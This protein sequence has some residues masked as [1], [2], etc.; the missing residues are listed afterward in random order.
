MMERPDCGRMTGS[1]S[2][3][4]PRM[5]AT[6]MQHWP[7]R[8]RNCRGR[9]KMIPPRNRCPAGDR[10]IT[11]RGREDNRMLSTEGRIEPAPRFAIV[12]YA[13]RFPG[14]QDA[15]E[16]WDVL[17]EGRDAISEVPKDRW[18]V[19]EFFDPEPGV[20]GKVVTRRAGFVDDVTGFDAP[21]FGMST[22][23]VMLM[24]PQ[25]LLLLKKA[26]L[27]ER[28]QATAPTHMVNTNT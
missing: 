5:S 6:H 21:F 1:R 2:S 10:I 12:G 8:G 19:D 4:N 16:F 11:G 24:D 18:D 25:H 14:A 27:R 3:R 15:D 9:R 13:A 22:R 17:R 20:P 28:N 23:E 26:G 7:V